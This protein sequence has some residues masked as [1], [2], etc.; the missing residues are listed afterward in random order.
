M[1]M[2]LSTSEFQ[3]QE[4]RIFFLDGQTPHRVLGRGPALTL[5]VR[6]IDK[7]YQTIA[8]NA[9]DQPNWDGVNQQEIGLDLEDA[10]ALMNAAI[11]MIR[12]QME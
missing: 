5:Y 12:V 8:R 3:P 9:S 4:G 6:G 10:E 7:P 2:E 11:S 1:S